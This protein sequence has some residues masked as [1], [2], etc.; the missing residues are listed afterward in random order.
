LLEVGA[1]SGL[2]I[3][4]AH[5]LGLDATGVEPSRSLVAAAQRLNGVELLQGTFPHPQLQGRQF[6]LIYIVDVIEHLD[7]PVRMLEACS[8]ALSSH[9]V[10]VVVTP[11]VSSLAARIL[12]HRWW[13]F[14]LAHVGY[15]NNRS[16]R[17][18]ARKTGLAVQS[19]RR[20]QWFFPIHY[21][22]ERVAQYLPIRPINR[23]A[24]NFGP[25]RRLYD[26]V[27][28]LNLHDSSAFTMVRKG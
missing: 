16:M 9:G 18:A 2:L 10:L 13:H 17:E 5:R 22:A 15:F 8:A 4:E 6:D 3:A 21:L 11:D 1:G 27:I 26:C 12:R 25:L 14:R 23:I 7:D 19:I 28:P 20:V 24:S